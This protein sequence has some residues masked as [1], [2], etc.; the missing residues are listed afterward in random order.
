MLLNRIQSPFLLLIGG[1][2]PVLANDCFLSG[3]QTNHI[4]VSNLLLVVWVQ[5][6]EEGLSLILVQANLHLLDQLNELSFV[7]DSILVSVDA[8]EQL[9]EAIQKLLV[10]GQLEY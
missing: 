3:Q 4:A 7:N 9:Q 10:L 5:V 1:I 2:E 6:L 8:S